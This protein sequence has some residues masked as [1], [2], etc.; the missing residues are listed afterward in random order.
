MLAPLGLFM[1]HLRSTEVELR[2]VLILT[3]NQDLG[4]FESGPLG[5]IQQTEARIT[6]VGDARAVDTDPYAVR[7]AGTSYLPGLVAPARAFHPKLVLLVGE[8]SATAAIG[9]GNLTLGG[10]QGNDEL[11]SIHKADG[12]GGSSVFAVLAGWLR[13]LRRDLR[14]SAGVAEAFDRTSELL[15]GLP[16]SDDDIAVATTDSAPMID[17]LPA[18]PVESLYLYAPFVDPRSAAVTALLDRMQPRTLTVA[19]QRQ[20]GQLNGASLAAAVGADAKIIELP[21]RPYRHGKLI[22]WVRDGERFALTGSANLSPSALLHPYQ[23]GGNIELGIVSAVSERLMPVGVEITVSDLATIPYRPRPSKSTPGVTVLSCTKTLHGLR[24]VFAQPARTAAIAQVSHRAGPPDQW[25]D[26]GSVAAGSADV[27][28]EPEAAP[29]SL[30]RVAFVGGISNAV[31]VCDLTRV[32]AARS[33]PRPKREL[34]SLDQVLDDASA[35]EALFRVFDEISKAGPTVMPPRATGSSGGQPGVYA[36]R[37]WRDYLS[38]CEARLGVHAIAFALGLSPQHGQAHGQE[39][40]W[41]DDVIDDGVVGVLDD[42]DPEE[43][44]EAKERI[45]QSLSQ[46]AEAERVRYQRVADSLVHG[47]I[48]APIHEQL[49]ALRLTLLLVAAGAWPSSDLRWVD[50]VLDSVTAITKGELG[51]EPSVGEAAGSLVALSLSV[52]HASLPARESTLRHNRFRR[53]ADDS[54]FLF[55]AFSEAKVAEYADGLEGR[56]RWSTSPA[57]VLWLC[58]SLVLSDPVA[59]AVVALEQQGIPARQQGTLIRLLRPVPEPDLPAFIA[60]VE[61]ESAN[62]V[63]IVSPGIGGDWATVLWRKPDLVVIRPGKDPAKRH[64]RWYQYRSGAR[65]SADIRT[66]DRPQ[67]DRTK[68]STVAGQPLLDIATEL[69]QAVGLTNPAPADE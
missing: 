69:L 62:V 8:H 15:D 58:E 59:A 6:V 5:L 42:D 48:D 61:S 2:E 14:F 53:V 4:F 51:D 9:S 13:S 20:L 37:D 44:K 7:R 17:A 1:R 50:L 68:G 52:V 18:A 25:V 39:T 47:R 41:D 11:W 63:A 49:F 31:P 24:L 57:A 19:V 45:G 38:A 46:R 29:G 43:V 66:S 10:W 55:A 30:V 16:K 56:W 36:P 60:L 21:D 12:K 23:R 54:S 67:Q 33:V 64:C 27:D 65:P 40:D 22:E 28:L 34:P 35:I 26:L 32:L 3:Y